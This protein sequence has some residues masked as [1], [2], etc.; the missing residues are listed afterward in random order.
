M[1]K[2]LSTEPFSQ[3]AALITM[4]GPVSLRLFL[5][6]HFLPFL[7]CLRKADRDRLLPALDLAA[8]AASAC[9]GFALLVAAHLAFHVVA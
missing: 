6:G 3:L 4:S 9:F 8:L 2:M 7:T 5:L 1:K